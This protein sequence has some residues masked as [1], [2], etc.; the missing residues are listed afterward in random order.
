[1]RLLRDRNKKAPKKYMFEALM[2][3]L[4]EVLEI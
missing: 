1:M 2:M 4:I 3:Y